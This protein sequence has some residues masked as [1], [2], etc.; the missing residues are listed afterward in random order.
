MSRSS[1]RWIVVLLLTAVFCSP[2]FG[3]IK[4]KPVEAVQGKRYL[5]NKLHDPWLVMVTSLRNV[6]ESFRVDGL[7]A[8]EAADSIIYALRQ[9][10]IPAYAFH[11]KEQLDERGKYIE[12]QEYIAILA[13][14][15]QTPDERLARRVLK[16]IQQEFDLEFLHSESSGA[17]LRQ[18]AEGSMPFRRAFIA[19]NPLRSEAEEANLTIDPLIVKLNSESGDVS[20]LKNSGTFSLKVA[21]F[22]GNSI[23]LTDGVDTDKHTKHFENNFGRGVG[24]AGVSAWE[25]ATALRQAKRLG[26]TQN[27]DA[28]VYHDQYKSYVTV[29]A[30]KTPHDPRIAVLKKEFGAKIK[31]HPQTG[32]EEPVSE[33]FSI[34]K[35]PTGKA[36]PDKLWSFDKQPRLI[37]VPGKQIARTN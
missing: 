19:P 30:F 10:G 25:L 20:L 27:Y 14:G 1:Q 2:A 13:G 28:W 15:F 4:R 16:F 17:V 22:S 5:L 6:D 29:G 23:I 35:N 34:P 32:R 21:T 7:T 31:P 33:L 36:L 9:K 24:E 8:W 3:K 18:D 26:Y 11:Q 12:R 37:A